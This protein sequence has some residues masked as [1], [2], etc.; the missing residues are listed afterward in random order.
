VAGEG[1]W[2]WKFVG[3]LDLLA[4]CPPK[5]GVDLGVAIPLSQRGVAPGVFFPS[6]ASPLPSRP[7]HRAVWSHRP[8]DGRPLA[9]ALAAEAVVLRFVEGDGSANPGAARTSRARLSGD[10]SMCM[11]ASSNMMCWVAGPFRGRRSEPPRTRRRVIE[12]RRC[13]PRRTGLK[14]RTPGPPNRPQGG[15]SRHLLCVGQAA[16]GAARPAGGRRPRRGR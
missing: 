11:S 8:L 15:A 16:G 9:G 10:H 1:A 14:C 12:I 6:L 5:N 13:P 7:S 4:W 2:R 3:R